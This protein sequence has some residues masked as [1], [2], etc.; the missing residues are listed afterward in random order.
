MANQRTK[1]ETQNTPFHLYTSAAQS[2]SQTRVDQVKA[3]Q[4]II[5]TRWLTHATRKHQLKRCVSLM[6]HQHTSPV[7]CTRKRVKQ[8]TTNQKATQGATWTDTQAGKP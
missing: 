8:N 2:A 5:H 3:T 4:P 1:F 7:K 6:C